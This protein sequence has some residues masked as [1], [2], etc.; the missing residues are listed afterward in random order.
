MKANRVDKYIE[1]FDALFKIAESQQGL[2]TAKQAIEAGF[3]ERNHPY[4]VQTGNW[5]R[6]IR[7]VYRLKNFP[8]SDE[9]QLVLWSLWSRNKKDIPQGVYSFETAL[10]IYEL[11]DLMPTKLHMTVL[12][13][14][15]RR[16]K[17]PKI[18]KLYHENISE[19]DIRNMRGFSVT[20]PMRTLKDLIKRGISE[21]VI[22]QAMKEAFNRGLI[23]HSEHKTLNSL[24]KTKME[25]T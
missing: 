17:I 21:E 12:K 10:S 8:D 22:S 16:S 23:T 14:F 24:I 13:S 18:L 19:S 9:A 15:R 5:I 4:H 20:T 1:S 7:G 3:D 11:T 6:E 2:F 25:T